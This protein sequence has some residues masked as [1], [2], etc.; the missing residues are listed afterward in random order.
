MKIPNQQHFDRVLMPVAVEQ[1]LSISD[2]QVGML[3]G[4]ESER[5]EM[6][7]GA[8]IHIG[9]FIDENNKHLVTIQGTQQQVNQAFQIIR[10]ILSIN[11]DHPQDKTLFF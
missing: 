9:D 2:I 11:D 1:S 7:S 3:L 5:I 8:M 6:E 4:H 10:R